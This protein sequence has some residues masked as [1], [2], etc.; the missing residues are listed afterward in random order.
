MARSKPATTARNRKTVSRFQQFSGEGQHDPS[1]PPGYG[2]AETSDRMGGVPSGLAAAVQAA[3]HR[4][5]HMAPAALI[6]HPFNDPARS[7][8]DLD[9]PQWRA[10]LDNVGAVGVVNPV[11]A[12]TRAAFCTA[13]PSLAEILSGEG[14]H[15]LIYGH[16]RLA[17]AIAKSIETIPVVVDDS[18]LA[19]DGDLD[20]MVAENLGRSDLSP[21]AE[22]ALYAHYSEELHLPQ[23]KI[24]ARLGVDQATVSRRLSLL[25][26]TPAATQSLTGGD[27]PVATA[28]A[29][30]GAL[31]Y[32]PPR[33]W[34]K[35]P[36]AAQSSR[37]RELD[38]DAALRLVLDTNV[39]PSR[40]A[41]RVLAVRDARARAD[42]LGIRVIDDPAH[43]IGPNYLTHQID[44]VPD[45][46]SDEV[47][48]AIDPMMGG[49]I[50]YLR[51]LPPATTT[52]DPADVSTPDG[53]GAGPERPD[54]PDD[55][56]SESGARDSVIDLAQDTAREGRAQ[57]LPIAAENV[58]PKV[59]MLEI[60]V[61]A[62]AA[63]VDL[64][65]RAVIARA[66]MWDTSG[67]S[68]GDRFKI[69][70]AIVWRRLLAGY[71]DRVDR[72]NKWSEHG[73]TYLEIL[74]DRA[75]YTP[76]AWERRQSRRRARE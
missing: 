19:N 31:P 38:Q 57:A 36:E 18:V 16:R 21:L 33:R 2:P 13:R 67:G 46:N 39:S 72:L 9:D 64:Q 51:D 75:R 35:S 6:P 12:V 43:E 34:Q 55:E 50:F 74:H 7:V 69:E 62:I 44:E 32:G 70:A 30:A 5:R 58:P 52:T 65:S 11:L 20:L 22:A 14:T 53:D 29:L 47:I 49:L 27:L 4:I 59:K 48:A 54:E 56:D 17:A 71:E 26:L 66:D 28:A 42:A 10:L 24:A 23:Q 40:A 45:G 76:T 68:P 73:D 63:G 3:G 1:Q 25:L 8:P 37:E 15:V 41:E 60:L 61:E